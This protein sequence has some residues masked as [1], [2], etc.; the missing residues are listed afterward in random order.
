[1]KVYIT[2]PSVTLILVKQP[3]DCQLEILAGLLA[4]STLDTRKHRSFFFH[5]ASVLRP[6]KLFLDYGPR[7]AKLLK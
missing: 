7:I 1:M 2:D 4:V 5:F 6:S 3:Y